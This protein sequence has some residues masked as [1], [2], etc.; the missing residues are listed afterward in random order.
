MAYAVVAIA[1]VW[2]LP[3]HLSTHLTGDPS[4][5]AG[6]YVWNQWVFQHEL[7]ERG[8]SPYFTETIFASGAP[9]NLSLHNYTPFQNLVALP[10]IPVFGVVAAF[11]IVQLLMRVL[12]AYATFLLAKRVTGRA[13]EAWIAGL[14]FAWSP[15]M[16]TRGLGH[17]SLIAAAPLAVFLLLLIRAD[18]V[19]RETGR[20]SARLACALGLTATWA[21]MTDVYYAV[22][23]VII[24]ALYISGRILTMRRARPALPTLR[25]TLDVLLI[26]VAVVAMSIL[27]SGGW[28]FTLLGV[29]VR[30]KSL[31]T[32][33]LVIT[34]LAIVRALWAYR[35]SIELNLAGL[36]S[37]VRSA[38]IAG[39]VGVV[40]LSPV[41]YAAGERIIEGRWESPAIFWRSSPPGA[42]LLALV[43]PNPNHPL[44][45]QGLVDWLTSRPNGYLENV[46]SLPLVGLAVLLAAWWSGWRAPRLWVGMTAAFGLL[47][48]GPFVQIGGINTLVPG[49]WALL[50]YVPIVGLARTPTRFAVVLT[51]GVAVLVAAAL[52]WLGTRYPQQRRRMLVLAVLVLGFELLPS[53]RP[54]FSAAIPRIYRHVAAAPADMGI[55]E[56]PFGL[57]DGA[58]STGNA[59]ARSQFFQTSHGK[60]LQ[61]GYLSRVSRRRI[62]ETR[63]NEVLDALI[64]LSEGGALAPDRARSLRDLGPDYVRRSRLGFVVVD[65]LRASEALRV[66]AVEAFDLRLVES[67]GPFELYA[68]APR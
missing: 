49:P 31:Y 14:V 27:V 19:Y 40:L 32:P 30:M 36:W 22:Y 18:D 15:L 46:V 66:A 63:K 11:N 43:L 9:A 12:T 28:A 47:A 7:L 45:P 29:D 8:K 62:S 4:G 42:D 39:V 3:L 61:G 33:M 17:H 13:P 56:L 2:P 64:T 25:R 65:R 41:L 59:T 24:G 52:A 20:V 5:D 37:F 51:L 68:P 34:A 57:R 23:C 58:S 10:L 44:A 67:D 60:S 35:I 54:M 53:P 26:L 55:L 6:V 1:F 50:R 48:L 21:A 38:A 16:I